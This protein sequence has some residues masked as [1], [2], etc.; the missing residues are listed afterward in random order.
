MSKVVI[1]IDDIADFFGQILQLFVVLLSNNIPIVI[2]PFEIKNHNFNNQ[3]M[4]I[5]PELHL[6]YG[7]FAGVLIVHWTKIAIFNMPGKGC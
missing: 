3:I 6:P 4:R 5:T 2:K 7:R 1:A